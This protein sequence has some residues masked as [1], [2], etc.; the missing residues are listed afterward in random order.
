MA[1]GENLCRTV[2]RDYLWRR[3]LWTPRD[4]QGRPSR[5]RVSAQPGW[6]SG[7]WVM[8]EY[9]YARSAGA[10]MTDPAPHDAPVAALQAVLPALRRL[11]LLLDRA[12]ASAVDAYGPAAAEEFRGLH[13]SQEECERL[14]R[15]EPGSPA[16][17]TRRN[18]IEAPSTEV[19]PNDPLHRLARLFDLSGFDVDI[20][21]IALAPE[22]DLRYERLYSYLQDNVTSRRPTVDLALNLLCGSAVE[23]LTRHRHFSAAAPLIR[24]GLIEFPPDPPGAQ[25]P[26]LAREIKIDPQIVRYLLGQPELDPRLTAFCELHRPSAPLIQSPIA[27][28]LRNRLRVTAGR[29]MKSRD[30]LGLYFSGRPGVG[31]RRAASGLAFEMG[32]KLLTADLEAL[33]VSAESTPEIVRVLFHDALLSAAVL[34][35]TGLDE[36]EGS[37]RRLLLRC[38]LDNLEKHRGVVVFAGR[39]SWP[40]DGLPVNRVPIITVEFPPPEFEHRRSHWRK[41]LDAEG[42]DVPDREVAALAGRFRLTPGGIERVLAEART[43]ASWR[44]AGLARRARGPG[45]ASGHPGRT[46]VADLFAA[47]RAASGSQLA[48]LARK[49]ELKQS[50][51]DIVLPDDQLNQIREICQQAA[52]RHT[53]YD[54]WGFGRKLSLG[55]GLNILFAGPPGT[56]KTMAAEVI[57]GELQLDLYTIDLASVVSKY[58]GETEKNLDR[59]FTAAEWASAVLLFDE[60]DALYGKRSEVRDA[61]DRYANIEVGYLLQKMD[62]YEGIAVLA[63]NVRHHLDEAFLR[64]MHAVVEFPVPDEDLRRRIWDVV[65]PPEAP[66]DPLVDFAFLAREVSL[67]GG[68]IRNIA[69]AAAFLAA[70]DGQ[71]IGMA[72]LAKAARREYQKVG[73]TWREAQWATVGVQPTMDESQVGL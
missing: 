48:A 30:P 73:R 36:A 29:V 8:T 68:N 38:L 27:E 33:P 31:K 55:R 10:G 18:G 23:K 24:R 65:F 39:G 40:G 11:D 72:H 28:D 44:D 67:T 56:G 63:T 5:Q 2:D 42:I 35:L 43:R 22:L 9:E 3:A 1:N 20:L 57:A 41:L 54:K 21:L 58:I 32:A 17:S 49:I 47:A 62:D 6:Y 15:L 13:I 26:L 70:A 45:S 34:Y 46:T 51:P 64:R 12:V 14:L 66:V 37:H 7:L 50:W 59:V 60:A 4:A 16:I 19:S 52:S 69:L 53:V 71:V 61:H 25:P